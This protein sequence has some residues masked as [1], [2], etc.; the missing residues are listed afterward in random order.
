MELV[1]TV[2]VEVFVRTGTSDGPAVVLD[3]PNTEDELVMVGHMI[4]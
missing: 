3:D 2:T 1:D 4:D